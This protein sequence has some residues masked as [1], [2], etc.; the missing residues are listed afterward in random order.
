MAKLFII[1]VLGGALLGEVA[2]E[3][4]PPLLIDGAQPTVT[5]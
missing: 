1:L 5:R 4:E 2:P 3:P